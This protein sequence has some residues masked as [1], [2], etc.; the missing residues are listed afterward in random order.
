MNLESCLDGLIEHLRGDLRHALLKAQIAQE[1]AFDP[2]A[3]SPTGPLGLTQF[4]RAT[5]EDIMPGHPPEDRVD[6]YYAI[7]AQVKYMTRLVQWSATRFQPADVEAGALAAYNAGQGNIARCQAEASHRGH[8]P[9]VWAFVRDCLPTIVGPQKAAET[10]QYVDKILT[11]AA[12]YS[13]KVDK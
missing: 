7:L 11:H 13:G 10:Q 8:Q 9:E 1:S 2:F 12:I 5:W 4:T 6:I 3:K